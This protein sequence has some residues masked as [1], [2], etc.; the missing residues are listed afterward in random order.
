MP[1][2]KHPVATAHK[3]EDADLVKIL[4]DSITE[5]LESG[6]SRD[7]LEGTKKRCVIKDIPHLYK[8]LGVSI[9]NHDENNLRVEVCVSLR[10]GGRTTKSIRR[11]SDC[12]ELYQHDGF[13][14]YKTL[15]RL[16]ANSNIAE[17]LEKRALLFDGW[18]E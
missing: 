4:N 17:A 1:K 6:K 5:T 3:G 12:W 15:E 18:L 8:L 10:G 11:F 2:T 9:I 14:E 16:M 13:T 7:D